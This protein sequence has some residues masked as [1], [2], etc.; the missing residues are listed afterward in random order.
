MD[1]LGNYFNNVKTPRT[2]FTKKSFAFPL[3][4]SNLGPGKEIQRIQK[5][6]NFFCALLTKIK[7]IRV[8]E[9]RSSQCWMFWKATNLLLHLST[10]FMGFEQ[11]IV[12]PD[13]S[14]PW[15]QK[16]TIFLYGCKKPWDLGASISWSLFWCSFLC[17]TRV[18]DALWPLL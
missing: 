14:F 12:P 7:I 11:A 15:Q 16:S 5:R 1:F 2:Y 8:V 18:L 6:S 13:K 10:T 3:L 4:V 9:L 17:C